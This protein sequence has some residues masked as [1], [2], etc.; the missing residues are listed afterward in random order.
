M[1]SP[2]FL[3]GALIFGLAVAVFLKYKPITLTG[4][5]SGMA[6]APGMQESQIAKISILAAL[7]Y[8]CISMLV[9]HLNRSNRGY[10]KIMHYVHPEKLAQMFT[11]E[12]PNQEHMVGNVSFDV[13]T[14][15]QALPDTQVMTEVPPETSSGVPT[16]IR[17]EM[18]HQTNPFSNM[19]AKF[20]H[21]PTVNSKR[22]IG[23]AYAGY[24]CPGS[25]D[26]PSIKP[27]TYNLNNCEEDLINTGLLFNNDSPHHPLLHQGQ[28]EKDP[29]PEFRQVRDMVN[30]QRYNYP[31]YHHHSKGYFVPS[32]ADYPNGIP[33]TE[34]PNV[35]C[36][37]KKRDLY[38]Q[39]NHNTMT[40]DTHYGRARVDNT[41]FEG[42]D[43]S[44]IGWDQIM[45]PFN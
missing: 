10:R 9:T 32:G 39:E 20:H 23:A 4:D 17:P 11:M 36:D 5:S 13:N 22:P 34:A 30:H 19:M 42:K 15:S 26:K 18:M 14:S 43:R 37:S 33:Y 31:Q 12:T 27:I 3:V 41:V 29:M 21:K 16:M 38:Y 45:G 40:P 28:F 24:A 6:L 2:R 8:L 1:Y 7:G 35:I 44:Y 25:C